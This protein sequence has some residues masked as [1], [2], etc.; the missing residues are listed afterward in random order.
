LLNNLGALAYYQGRWSE[1]LRLYGEARRNFEKVGNLVDAAL[2]TSNIAEIFADQGRLDEAERLLVEVI[3]T[4]RSLA[5]PL[6][7]A[8]A[9]R[10]L[11][12]VHLRRGDAAT[13]QRHF[14]SARATF[15]EYGLV[16]NVHEVDVWRAECLLR[17]G[18]TAEAEALLDEA[19]ALEVSNGST[20]LRPMVHRLRAGAAAAR[21]RIDDAWAEI[22]ESLHHARSRGAAFDVAL[23]LE[24]MGV[25]AR[26]GGRP[27]EEDARREREQL[28]SS[29]GV[30][31][32]PPPLIEVSAARD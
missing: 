14:E 6:G 20:D 30:V 19:L 27:L 21:L 8:R 16:G 24:T 4:W 28:L 12:R 1:A 2:G 31:A 18:R 22:D 32:S 17:L 23:A 11:A 7:T 29:L 3:E 15:E 25:L 9:T 13:A 10:Y 26:L 5:F